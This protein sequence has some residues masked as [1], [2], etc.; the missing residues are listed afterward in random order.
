MFLWLHFTWSIIPIFYL[1]LSLDHKLTYALVKS[2]VLGVT[3]RVY[4]HPDEMNGIK[5]T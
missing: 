3:V 1:F 5:R 4:N 2:A